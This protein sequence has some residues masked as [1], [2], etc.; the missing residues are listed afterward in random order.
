[1]NLKKRSFDMKARAVMQMPQPLT[2]EQL[3]ELKREEETTEI[4]EG[5]GVNE[6]IKIELQPVTSEDAS[7]SM[8]SPYGIQRPNEK[9]TITPIISD[10][11]KFSYIRF[12][13][14]N[15]FIGPVD[16]YINGRLL[17][18]DHDYQEFSEYMKVLPGSYRIEVFKVG[19]T[20]NP[21]NVSQFNIIDGRIYTAALVG[22]D[23]DVSWQLIVDNRRALNPNIAYI[24]FIQLSPNAPLMDVYVDER[25]VISDLDYKEV[26]RYLFLIPGEHSIK[27]KVAMSD[28]LILVDPSMILKGGRAYTVYIV[29]N[30]NEHPGLQVLIPL[31]GVSYLEF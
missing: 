7:E 5:T 25:L 24:R 6:G 20:E 12:L 10:M 8:F 2:E 29:G 16:V 23:E 27:L 18:S 3:K 30:M 17:L 1:M 31:E 14:A 19:T 22:T 13:N 11:S 15:A 26:S 28:R 21:L 4:L 9:V